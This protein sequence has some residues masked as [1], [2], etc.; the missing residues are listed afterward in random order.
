M[1]RETPDLVRALLRNRPLQR[2]KA[3]PITAQA[4]GIPQGPRTGLV[5]AA[6]RSAATTMNDENVTAS[7]AS[8]GEE[9][10]D[11]AVSGLCC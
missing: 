6:R 9:T 2:F 7:A 10:G 4:R 8:G 3:W 5:F 11:V 1:V